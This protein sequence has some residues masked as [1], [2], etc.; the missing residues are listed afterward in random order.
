MLCDNCDNMEFIELHP[1][2]FFS[3]EQ[4]ISCCV[5]V[6]FSSLHYNYV[7]SFVYYVR[8]V[9]HNMCRLRVLVLC[10][11]LQLCSICYI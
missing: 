6:V 5:C 8:V 10:L 4:L 3:D 1:A 11:V 2:A 7:E 9:V